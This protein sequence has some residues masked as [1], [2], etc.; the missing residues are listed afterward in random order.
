MGYFAAFYVAKRQWHKTFN[1]GSE[2]VNDISM[3]G[4]F[5][6]G[7]FAGF[8]SW[9]VSYPQDIVKTKLQVKSYQYPMYNSFIRDG[10]FIRCAQSIY[11]KKGLKGFFVGFGAC[12]VRGVIVG[13]VEL[14][15]YDTMS[16]YFQSH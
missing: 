13:A 16:L 10:G 4:R 15:T 3:L 8:F 7:G 2:D 1:P 5:I 11:R 14:T 12:A 9:V 6:S